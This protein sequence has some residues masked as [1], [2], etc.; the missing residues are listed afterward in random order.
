MRPRRAL[1]LGRL[2]ADQGVAAALFGPWH[3]LFL[4]ASR[5]IEL[6]WQGHRRGPPQRWAS[7]RIR[8]CS[9]RWPREASGRCAGRLEHVK[10]K[11]VIPLMQGDAVDRYHWMTDAQF[12]NAVA[13]VQATPGP[14]VHAVFQAPW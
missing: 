2:R 5:L 12:L 7:R 8:C 10:V 11:V 3:V 9:A 4:L 6:G 13:L 1:A 14:V